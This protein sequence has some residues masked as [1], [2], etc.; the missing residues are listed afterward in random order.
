MK[1]S[2]AADVE[3]RTETVVYIGPNLKF[4]ASGTALNNG[5]TEELKQAISKTPMLEKLVVP[6]NILAQAKSDLR[7][8]G[9]QLNVIYNQLLKEVNK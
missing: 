8:K 3:H 5:Y 7:V 1:K 2:K 6:I 4:L 9:S